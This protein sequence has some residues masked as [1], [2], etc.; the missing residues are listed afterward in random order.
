VTL[1]E[2]DTVSRTGGLRGVGCSSGRV[3]A[4]ARVVLDCHRD[5]DVAGHILVARST[6]PAWIFLMMKAAGLVV[7]RGSVLSHTAIVG[8][9]LGIPTVVGVR[10]ATSKIAD[11]DL[12]TIDGST[13]DVSWT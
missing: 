11:G 5:H 13:G 4:P 2:V 8:R 3:S 12:L 10:D 9:E 6:D 1:E 7:E